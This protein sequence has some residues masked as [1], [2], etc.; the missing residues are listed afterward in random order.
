VDLK[1][2]AGGDIGTSDIDVGF[3]TGYDGPFNLGDSVSRLANILT[4]LVFIGSK[5]AGIAAMS[6]RSIRLRNNVFIK[7]SEITF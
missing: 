3:P 7:G 2:G 1:Q 4:F 6:R 5:G